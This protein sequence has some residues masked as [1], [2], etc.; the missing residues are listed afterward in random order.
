MKY[1]CQ[2]HVGL[3]RKN[4]E[5]ALL[6]DSP[7]LFAVADGVGGSN[8]GEIA[9]KTALDLLKKEFYTQLRFGQN[10]VYALRRAISAV[11]TEIYFMAHSQ[12]QYAG[13]GTTLTAVYLENPVLAHVLQVG[14]SRLYLWREGVLRQV[15]RDQTLVGEMVAAGEITEQ[16]GKLHS[17]KNWLLQAVGV[18]NVIQAELLRLDLQPGDRMLLCSDGL[19]N[20]LS[21]EEIVEGLAKADV[22]TA[23]EMLLQRALENGGEDNITLIVIDGF[24]E[25]ESHGR[26]N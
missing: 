10:P 11:N 14:D 18:E 5:D 8:A 25:E 12:E 20:M 13:M 19:S 26:N 1:Y 24:T 9:S 16:E 6:A 23:G 21:R 3:V 15:T 2:T 4:N 22:R 17:K 7:R